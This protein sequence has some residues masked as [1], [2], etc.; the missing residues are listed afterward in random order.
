M[1]DL[2]IPTA[3]KKSLAER[4]NKIPVTNSNALHLA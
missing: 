1:T 3:A 4:S 2:E